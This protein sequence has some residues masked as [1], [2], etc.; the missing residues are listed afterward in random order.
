MV[1]RRTP[2][3]STSGSGGG[4]EA[5][6]HPTADVTSG[7]FSVARGGTGL[8]TVAVG[9]F[10]S[11]NGT[12]AL[13]PRTTAEVLADIGAAASTHNHAASDINTGTLAVA[14]GGTG[15][16]SVTSGSY[17]R[18]AGTSALVERTPSE[19]LADIG[20]A[21][22]SHAHATTDITSGTLG[23]ARGGTGIASYTADNYIRASGSTTL[24]QRTPTQVRSDIGAAASSHAHIAYTPV[25]LTDAATIATDASL[26]NHFRVT[27]GGNR[28]LGNPTNP[29][30]G[31]R[32]LWEIIQD[33]TGS[34]T[35]A[36]D[37]A[38]AFGT[39]ITG[40]TLTTTASKRD[41]IGAVYNS[42]ASKWY[43]IAVSKGY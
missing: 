3:V 37:T 2:G 10:L 22:S 34:R 24:E 30:D 9:S 25:A 12:S 35:L 27:L 32:I 40:V 41:F 36:F 11:G 8:N 5:H 15:V 14:R 33:A 31:Q 1:A 42:T 29:T 7:S 21:A 13:V 20:A 16:A 17:L 6:T 39:D 18:G 43:I 23:V 4:G 28:T 19:V 26:G 38:F